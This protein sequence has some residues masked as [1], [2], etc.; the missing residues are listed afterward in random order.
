MRR[1]Q[2]GELVS[3]T[4]QLPAL[5]PTA[6]MPAVEL[7]DLLR[8]DRELDDREPD[9]APIAA[10]HFDASVRYDTTLVGR[11]GPVSELAMGT[12]RIERQSRA[13]I[14]LLVLGCVLAF[15]GGFALTLPLWW[16]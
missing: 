14:M 12:A 16:Q 3:L 8:K 13:A 5:R 9:P 10:E 15:G 1:D 2:L 11:L 4:S 6:E 7:Q